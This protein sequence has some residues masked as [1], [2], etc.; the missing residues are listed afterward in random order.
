MRLQN[1]S[2]IWE[3]YTFWVDTM[4]KF[5]SSLLPG[6]ILDRACEL[7]MTHLIQFISPALPWRISKSL[8]MLSEVAPNKLAFM[9]NTGL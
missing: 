8:P 7:V 5:K 6:V 1:N 2:N 4:R 3:N 9:L